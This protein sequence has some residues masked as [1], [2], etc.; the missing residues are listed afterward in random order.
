MKPYLI[1]GFLSIA[2]F[3]KLGYDMNLGVDGYLIAEAKD[4]GMPILELESQVGQL[5]MMND[6]S[7]QLQEAFLENAISAVESGKSPDQVTGMVNAWQSGDV[8]LMQEVG[9]SVNKGARMNDQLDEILI[10][11]RHGE[12][13]KKLE[14]YLDSRVTHF[15]AVGSLHLVGPRGLVEMLKA[16]GY[17]VKQL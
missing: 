8:E 1:G 12:M 15:V 7:P 16:R 14:S 17:E 13:L 3:S 4:K 5:N 10:Y 11:G 2:E 9:R 6:M